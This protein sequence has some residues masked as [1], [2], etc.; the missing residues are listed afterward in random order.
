MN[1]K[2]KRA[3]FR[4]LRMLRETGGRKRTVI[5]G[6]AGGDREVLDGLLSEGKVVMRGTRKGAIYEHA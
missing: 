2:T 6:L 4:V 1:K 3:R 5:D